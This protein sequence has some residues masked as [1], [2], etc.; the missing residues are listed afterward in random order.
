MIILDTHVWWWAISE[1]E[2]L[3]WTAKKIID[4]TPS[5]ERFIASISFWEFAMMV[6]RGRVI[7]KISPKEWFRHAVD[8]AGTKVA[9]LTDEIALDACNLPGS[10]HKDPADRIIV[11]TARKFGAILVTKDEKILNYPD[12]KSIW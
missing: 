11:A 7:L 3:S 8:V 4:E 6:S 2:K 5:G 1:P 9:D 10:F 12:V